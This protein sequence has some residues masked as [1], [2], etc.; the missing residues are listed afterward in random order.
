MNGENSPRG[1]EQQSLPVRQIILM[2]LIFLAVAVLPLFV[3]RDRANIQDVSLPEIVGVIE[4]GELKTLIVRGD[5]LVATKTDGSRLSARKESNIST[6]ARS[7]MLREMHP[8]SA[9][10]PLC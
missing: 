4:A 3:N 7:A 5:Q 9:A 10:I 2:A 8:K 6:G 1:K